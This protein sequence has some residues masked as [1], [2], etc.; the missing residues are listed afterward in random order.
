MAGSLQDQ[1]LN[2]G[3][4]NKKK[5]KRIDI[6]KR[7]QA[8]QHRKNK[9]QA[10]DKTKERVDKEIAEEKEKSRLL[11]A[12]IIQEAEQ[13]AFTAQI[14]QLIN[15]NRIDKRHEKKDSQTINKQ[16][17]EVAY[18]F[19]D[20]G[21]VKQIYITAALKKALGLG[22]L[23]IVKYDENYELVPYVVAKKILDRDKNCVVQI[24]Q[25][26][27]KKENQEDDPYADYQI[28]DDLMW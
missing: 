27:T 26:E 11:N 20:S 15:L 24:K 13:K 6:E 1:L 19:T 9:T 28:P 18:N 17:T 10:S 22:Q 14:K 16:T 21:K 3:L 25:Y 4:S 2:M 12:K 7:K 5:A 23:A 8:K